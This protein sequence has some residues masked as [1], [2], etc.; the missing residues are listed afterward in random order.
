M[1]N[2]HGMIRKIST[3][4]WILNLPPMMLCETIFGELHSKFT[5]LS[6]AILLSIIPKFWAQK[7]PFPGVCYKFY[8]KDVRN[9]DL[10]NYTNCIV[11][12]ADLP[13]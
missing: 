13:V 1:S 9:F 7:S 6:S 4:Q 10:F 8:L 11:H 5:N 12:F 3:D 2:I